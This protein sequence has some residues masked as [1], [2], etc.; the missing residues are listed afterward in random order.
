MVF[1][2]KREV[3]EVREGLYS[4]NFYLEQA[5]KN[6]ARNLASG[7][8][9]THRLKAANNWLRGENK[10]ESASDKSP[11]LSV[12]DRWKRK[13]R[14]A[15][16]DRFSLDQRLKRPSNSRLSIGALLCMPAFCLESLS[17]PRVSAALLVLVS[18]VCWSQQSNRY[19]AMLSLGLWKFRY[20][21]ELKGL[22]RLSPN[23]EARWRYA[24]ALPGRPD[25][26]SKKLL[27]APNGPLFRQRAPRFS[28][29]ATV[30]VGSQAATH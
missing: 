11:F 7:S 26:R 30:L 23:N 12:L 19:E 10:T 5:R 27:S 16:I 15:D 24:P 22:E 3:G 8:S 1:A 29:A 2:A 28:P 18:H 9:D 14:N 6:P 4:H 21:T 13:P 17:H 25:S 20:Q